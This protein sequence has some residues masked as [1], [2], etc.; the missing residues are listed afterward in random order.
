MQANLRI[1]KNTL[2]IYVRLI[3]TVLAGLVTSRLVLGALGIEG[4]GLYN[5]VG[6][7][8]ALFGFINAALAG[9]TQR[10]I[11]VEL[12]KADGNPRRVFNVCHV[13]HIASALLLLLVAEVVG[14]LYVTHLLNVPPGR[15]GDAMFVF[16][17]SVFA[18]CLGIANI[19]FQSMLTAFE[20]FRDVAIIDI[21]F[22]LVRLALVVLLL[23]CEGNLIRIYAVFMSSASILSFA[24]Y[25]LY[26]YRRWPDIVRW[27]FVRGREAYREPLS[28]SSYNLISA[29]S[30]VAKWQGG[31]L[32]LNYFLGTAVNA[33]YGI[34]ALVSGY[35]EKF[36][37]NIATAAA[38][39]LIQ[40][41]GGNDTD[42]TRYLTHTVS[43]LTLLINLMLF[44]TL[45]PDLEF[46]LGLWLGN[47]IPESAASFVLYS[48][49]L[50]LIGSTTVGLYQMINATGRIKWFKL[51]YTAL[52]LL[53]LVAAIPA[54]RYFAVPP[55]AILLIYIVCDAL[56]RILTL[57]LCKTELAYPVGPFMRQ[58]YTRPVAVA[59][60]MTV[61]T[62]LY[63]RLP[64]SG[65]LAHLGGVALSFAVVSLLC[66]FVG[67][68]P[69]E[70]RRIWGIFRR[71][72]HYTLR[73]WGTRLFPVRQMKRDVK[74][75]GLQ[76]DLEHPKD[77]NE[78]IL[79]LIS[80]P[81]SKGWGRYADKIVVRQY[82]AD[83]GYE[84]L[85]VPLAGVWR[86]VSEIDFAALPEKCILK[87][88]HDSGSSVVVDRSKGVDE[89]AV[90][91]F[92][93]KR[94]KR[95]F[96]YVGGERFYN[97]ISP[98]ILAEYLLEPD[99]G[100]QTIPDYKVWCFDGKPCYI[101]AC[102]DRSADSVASRLYDTAWTPCDDKV[103]FVSHWHPAGDR[104]RP[105]HLERMLEAAARLSKG[106]PEVRVD[107]YEAGGKLY[108][109]EMTFSSMG[110]RMEYFTPQFLR[111]LGDLCVLPYEDT[112]LSV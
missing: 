15:E 59:L 110:G 7:A 90:R 108:F 89:A 34:A 32:L 26:C 47:R 99:P 84:D 38:P 77:I 54:Y 22:T 82:V 36:T 52:Y 39:Q 44:F 86:K 93:E 28:F 100:A 8:V 64:L 2:F 109:G 53:A 75:L 101:W 5:V 10:F 72:T 80:H 29:S 37:G 1:A 94:L 27:E 85:L 76:M 92:L 107:F 78:K 21:F 98:R 73:N 91:S 111:E 19:P 62:L 23:F 106:F 56:S 83:C 6:S 25:H 30:N 104:P 67:L 81:A 68:T 24:L 57:V 55:Y 42:R 66:W 18:A 40:S 112:L 63:R 51:Q 14:T 4:Y 102:Y 48:L 45:V 97:E 88:N 41:Y 9:T 105:Q 71:K 12:G 43:R 3:V 79:W 50:G 13:V 46:L 61:F 70:R 16:Q 87:C 69:G 74:A 33:A 96:G 60:L 95:K 20:R 58:A 11:N 103:L 49:I 65:R 17:V 31:N 35:V